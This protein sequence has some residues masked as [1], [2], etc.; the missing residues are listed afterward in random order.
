V[1]SV[2]NKPILGAVALT[3][4]LQLAAIYVPVLQEFF[5]TTAL[6]AKDLS[7]SF[8]LSTVGFWAI[9][10]AKSIARRRAIP[11]LSQ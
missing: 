11:L 10:L 5:S 1:Q 6:S 9:E 3:F 2:T 7:L 8:L 4:V